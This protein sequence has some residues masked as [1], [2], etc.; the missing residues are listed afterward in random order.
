MIL[1]NIYIKSFI[2]GFVFPGVFV[3]A[4]AFYAQ[5]S[6]NFGFLVWELTLAPFI[7]G[8]WNVFYFVLQK[9]IPSLSI[10]L[11]GAFLGLL[12]GLSSLLYPQ[13]HIIHTE[14]LGKIISNFVNI[15]FFFHK[16]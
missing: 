5:I 13:G 9:R 8:L 14:A 2:T 3:V 7:Y 10:G 16:L 6:G 11:W 1:K 12:F 4:A 15:N